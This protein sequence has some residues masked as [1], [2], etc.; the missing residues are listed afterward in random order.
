MT[1]CVEETPEE[2]GQAMIRFAIRPVPPFRLDL[3][4]WTLRRDP[5]NEI[6][7]WDGRQYHRVRLIGDKQICGGVTGE[8]PEQ[9]KDREACGPV[10]LG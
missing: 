4:V 9:R 6:D 8:G 5:R 10:V 7:R 2:Q 1:V 3:T